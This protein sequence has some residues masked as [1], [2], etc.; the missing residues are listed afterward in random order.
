MAELVDLVHPTRSGR[1]GAPARAVISCEARW[2][3]TTNSGA[4]A[5][6]R[7]DN[8]APARRRRHGNDGEDRCQGGAGSVKAARRRSRTEAAAGADEEDGKARGAVAGWEGRTRARAGRGDVGAPARQLGQS[9]SDTWRRTA[10]R[11]CPARWKKCPSAVG[12]VRVGFA[13]RI[14]ITYL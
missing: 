8:E 9:R 13:P 12:R 4:A 1:R 10:K 2:R 6:A 5:G 14:R 3:T 11:T 7:D